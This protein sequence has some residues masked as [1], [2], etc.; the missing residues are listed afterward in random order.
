MHA[1]PKSTWLMRGGPCLSK[2]RTH[3]LGPCRLR[4]QG[5]PWKAQQVNLGLCSL[6]FGRGNLCTP[7]SISPGHSAA[8]A[9]SYFVRNGR[10]RC[11]GVRHRAPGGDWSP[12]G[13]SLGKAATR[14]CEGRAASFPPFTDL[15]NEWYRMGSGAGSTWK[16]NMRVM[17]GP[18][19]TQR[20]EGVGLHQAEE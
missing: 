6:L 4:L 8:L 9:W 12:F 17:H 3:T 1:S 13:Q 18:G 5:V 10:G 11:P 14:G 16:W 20:W 7:L 2:S 15:K 19:T